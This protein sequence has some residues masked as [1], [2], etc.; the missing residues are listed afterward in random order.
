[1]RH[2]RGQFPQELRQL[3]SL[4]SLAVVVAAVLMVVVT[5]RAQVEVAEL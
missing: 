3:M 1:M 5:T 2:V 4:L